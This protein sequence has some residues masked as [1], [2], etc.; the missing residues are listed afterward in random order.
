M[1]SSI[2]GL[3]EKL[4]ETGITIADL[5]F[6]INF[7]TNEK[8]SPQLAMRR[9]KSFEQLKAKLEDD[10]EKRSIEDLK[11]KLEQK[12]QELKSILTE[13]E[14]IMEIQKN[15]ETKS[16]LL[17][18]ENEELQHQIKLI[19]EMAID[20]NQ[21]ETESVNEYADSLNKILKDI[22]IIIERK[23]DLTA[24]LLPIHNIL[25][26]ILSEPDQYNFNIEDYLTAIEDNP[27]FSQQQLEPQ[28]NLQDESDK[29][30]EVIKKEDNEEKSV[31]ITENNQITRNISKIEPKKEVKS[32]ENEIDAKVIQILDLFLDFI[33][34]AS[35]D[36]SFKDRVSTICDMD[37]AYEYLGSIG[38][39]QLYSYST[40]GV[41]KQEELTKLIK[42]WK[43]DGVPR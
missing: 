32:K 37:E 41:E 5:D 21:D 14:S 15:L 4:K 6:I 12:D 31:E 19:Q 9:I 27:I 43:T 7:M 13:K 29:V 23:E 28:S 20:T 18:S 30:T 39:S 33:S 42:S 26:L 1:V 36:K 25:S 3:V 2:E 16:E 17:N 11:I 10:T 35:D 24:I 8:I 22:D 38:L 34:E 40:K